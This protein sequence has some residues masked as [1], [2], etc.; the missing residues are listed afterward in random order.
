MRCTRFL[1]AGVVW[2]AWPAACTQQ[3]DREDDAR[4]EE[5]LD[6]PRED[7][8][9]RQ[10]RDGYRARARSSIVRCRH[11]NSMTSGAVVPTIPCVKNIDAVRPGTRIVAKLAPPP[12]PAP[13]TTMP[14]PILPHQVAAPQRQVKARRIASGFPRPAGSSSNRL[15]PR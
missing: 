8:L 9:Y 11:E 12:V 7:L 15:L 2:G 4:T 3:R 14:Q 5:R 1:V 13:A 10:H 6:G